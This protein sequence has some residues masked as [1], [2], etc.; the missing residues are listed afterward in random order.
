MCIYIYIFGENLNCEIYYGH[1]DT[2]VKKLKFSLF[3]QYYN[4]FM[5]N[6]YFY[7]YI[8]VKCITIHICIYC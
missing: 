2:I 6:I 4:E 1:I 5:K 8:Y 7:L 3:L